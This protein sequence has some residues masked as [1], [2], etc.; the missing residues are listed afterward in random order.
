MFL[1]RAQE[2]SGATS[3]NWR[4]FPQ[5][6]E[7]AREGGGGGSHMMHVTRCNRRSYAWIRRVPGQFHSGITTYEVSS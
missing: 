7:Q 1:E 6:R 2:V 5:V 4:L 3:E